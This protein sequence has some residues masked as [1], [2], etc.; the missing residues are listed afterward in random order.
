MLGEYSIFQFLIFLVLVLVCLIIDL[1]VH[2]ADKAIT[3]K[4]AAIW[5]A[6]WVILSLSFAAYV[7]YSHGRGQAALFLSGYFLEKSL[8][9]D[10]LFVIMAVFTSFSVKGEY[11]HRVLYYG[12]I[13]ALVMRMLFIFVGTSLVEM[14]GKYVLFV[15][16]VFVLWTAWKMWYSLK[17]KHEEIVDYSGH[18]AVR[19]VKKVF[20]I[21]PYINGH[22]FFVKIEEASSV[23]WKATPLLLCLIVI[24]ITDVMFAF[25]SIPAIIAITGEPFLVY[26]SNIFAILGLRSLYFMLAAASRYLIHLEKA[27]VFI[28]AFIGLKMLSDV[29]GILH[30]G[31]MISLFVIALA[32]TVG[33]AASLIKPNA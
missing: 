18:W 17:K 11:Q 30:I 33:I 21:H 28:L 27:V 10:N 6:F 5:S 7:A 1:L 20:P 2:K 29:F 12:I 4:N 32:I 24:E 22:A 16:G 3:I 26:T 31:P 19:L 14:F 8:S 23:V 9:V 13:G 15:F 25:D